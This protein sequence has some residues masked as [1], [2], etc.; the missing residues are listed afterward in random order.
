VLP[1]LGAD[2]PHA[3]TPLVGR[4]REIA[5]IREM[6]LR[7][8]VPLL[9][10]TGPGGAGK[11]RVALHVAAE[12]ANDFA[13]GVCFVPLAAVQEP[14]LVAA[15]IAQAVGAPEVAARPVMDG[16]REALRHQEMLLVL[17]NFEH[18]VDAAPLI[19]ELL[20]TCPRLKVL[21][22]SRT[23]LRLSDEHEYLVP[24]LALP[25][26][27]QLPPLDDLAEVPGVA[28]FLQRAAAASPEFALTEENAATIA[29][30]CVRLDGLP[31]A[32]EL[33]A[34]R[35]RLLTPGGLLT[36][37][38][39]RLLMLTGGGRDQPRRLRTVRDAVAWSHDLL[40]PAEQILFRRL[41][42]FVGGF[43]LEA[44]EAMAS[45][46]APT[47]LLGREFPS[48][49]DLVGSLVGQSLLTREE[50]VA[51]EPRFGML[52][53]IREYALERLALSGEADDVRT[54]HATLLAELAEEAD[55]KLRGREQLSW[56]AR[57]E[58]EHD[59]LR[60]ALAWTLAQGESILALRLAGALHWFW[61]QHTHWA[62]GRRWLE[63]ALAGPGA[64][65][66]DS[67]RAKAL[68]GAGLLSF[69]L[70]DYASARTRLD[71]SIAVSRAIGDDHLLAYAL[72][73][74]AW[75]AYVQGD[76]AR[77]HELASESLALFRALEDC[78]GFVDAIC[79]LGFA[80]VIAS[81][82]T[83]QAPTLFAESLA[84]A[85]E[86]GDVRGIA[87]A[88]SCLGEE[89][90][91][92]GEYER[93]A[94]FYDV[95]LTHSRQLGQSPRIPHLIYY[96]TLHNLGHVSA[97][98]GDVHRGIGYFAEGLAPVQDLGDRR[99]Q[100]LCLAGMA[101]MA[102]RLQEQK[103][104]ARLFG[105]VEALLTA[106]GIMMEKVDL[107]ACDPPRNAA[108]DQLGIA[109]FTAAWEEGAA[110]PPQE[111]IAEALTFAARVSGAPA[112]VTPAAG[113]GLGLSPRELD[114]LRL[115]VEGQS[116]PEIAA[117]L[118]ISRATVRN[119]V[120]NI[121]AKLGVASRTAAATYALRH[122][123]D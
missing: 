76:Y 49:L 7:R 28:L 120:T 34:P 16:L 116:N 82:H 65:A 87:R 55:I 98:L 89:A 102:A 23:V 54:R 91:E 26:P 92:H 88:A 81:P 22:T 94:A 67:L 50:Q 4:D 1:P 115:L 42:V 84:G 48:V 58:A 73:C 93:A 118:F 107:A 17:D 117:A 105:A 46:L 10:L 19:I 14:S 44:A 110:L 72:L 59:N 29:E 11:T 3:R 119:H 13:D 123:L 104:A 61:F 38:T 95:A 64:S 56:L 25:D 101:A 74:Q 66:P 109:G 12:L 53:T 71:E 85:R 111:A 5:A 35:C 37:L 80:E 62:E 8:D 97:L 32:L 51:G 30:I 77:H 114:V 70:S 52:E 108:R 100:G 112:I 21:T 41:A 90:R 43:T 2:I 121:L 57:L 45:G 63:R 24:P 15:A 40:S 122:G 31:L 39:N 106:A 9:T 36:R 69:A 79:S 18:L 96:K 47:E 75:P 113:A 86:L 27:H 78:W 20:T 68:A 60:A 103:R 99:G 33:A 83:R 6:L